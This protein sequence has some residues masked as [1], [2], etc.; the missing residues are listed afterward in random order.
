MVSEGKKSPAFA[1]PN[2]NGEIV[3]L[4]QFA[5]SPLVLY[6][7]PKDNT[8]GCTKESCDF[9][10]NFGRLQAAGAVVLGISADSVESHRKFK[11]KYDLPFMLLSDIDHAALELFGAWKEKSM[12]GRIFLGIERST[13][14]IDKN[15][16]VVKIFRKVK[17]KG[18][19]DAVL[20]I[21]RGLP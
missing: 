4:K 8:P 2:E 13:F 5:G 16:I 6:F 9:R 11:E 1:L 10:D 15:G 12:Y 20:E 17:V 3:S 21:V 14:I 7:Y 18:H 19:V